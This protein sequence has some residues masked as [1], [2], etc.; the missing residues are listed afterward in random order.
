MLASLMLSLVMD[1]EWSNA[2]LKPAEEYPLDMQPYWKP[3]ISCVIHPQ[4]E[5]CEYYEKEA[6]EP[7]VRNL[8]ETSIRKP[9]D[10]S[11]YRVGKDVTPPK[12]RSRV[13]PEYTE[14]A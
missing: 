12:V 1:K 5:Q 10:P 7:G 4:T 11:V 2:F 6:R 9:G 13:E 3:F 14:V 8:K